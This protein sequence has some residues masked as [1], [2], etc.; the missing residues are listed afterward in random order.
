VEG[1]QTLIADDN[2]MTG[3][4]AGVNIEGSYCRLT[5]NA[6]DGNIIVTDDYNEIDDN[7][8][9]GVIQVNR[10]SGVLFPTFT[11]LYN[12]VKD[13]TC[14]DLEL[15]YANN[16]VLFGNNVVGPMSEGAEVNLFWSSNNFI[17]ENQITANN[18]YD[19][20]LYQSSNNTIEANDIPYLTEGVGIDAS[21]NNLFALNNFYGTSNSSI[22]YVDDVIAPSTNI[23]SDKGLGNYWGNYQTRYPDAAEV[24]NTGIGSLPYVINKNNTDPYPLL[25]SYNISNASIQ[26]PT[27]ISSVSQPN[28]TSPQATPL[29]TPTPTA[30]EFPSLLVVVL[31][32]LSMFSVA[33]IVRLR[34][35]ANLKQ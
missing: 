13:N 18:G 8:G 32:L 7:S 17:Y 2:I 19:L 28:P 3:E 25:S 26:L 27:W 10:A 9:C 29:P 6:M 30:P 14:Q 11:A 4:G 21:N 34:K 5:N 35:T 33:V 31:L 15:N 20:A 23:W 22:S 1:N 16:N 24:G 12:F